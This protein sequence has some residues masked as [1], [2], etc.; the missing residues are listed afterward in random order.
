MPH[1]QDGSPQTRVCLYNKFL[2][3]SSPGTHSSPVYPTYF[4]HCHR[5]YAH[6]LHIQGSHIQQKSTGNVQ[7]PS[8]LVLYQVL[9]EY[10]QVG[11]RGTSPLESWDTSN[12]QTH[13]F[14]LKE[15]HT[16]AVTKG[17]KGQNTVLQG[18]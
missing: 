16:Q 17:P 2:P 5:V 3:I 11:S 14:L 9:C 8:V 4:R 15:G 10:H 6:T 1:Q 18:A 12:P 13:P 7:K